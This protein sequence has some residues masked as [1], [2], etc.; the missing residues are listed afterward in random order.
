MSLSG[1]LS[2]LID[3]TGRSIKK[4]RQI[5]VISVKI[6]LNPRSLIFFLCFKKAKKQLL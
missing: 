2:Y 6:N 4:A 5:K 3:L 1:V